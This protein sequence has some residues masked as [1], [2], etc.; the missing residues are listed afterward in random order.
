MT[1]KFQIYKDKKKEFRW[2]LIATNGNI[3]ADSG[4]GY[5]RRGNVKKAI[6]RFCDAALA[7]VED[8]SIKK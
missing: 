7:V 6:V 2:R 5:T 3:L 8:L 4:E 1:M